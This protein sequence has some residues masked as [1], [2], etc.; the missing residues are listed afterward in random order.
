M[1]KFRVSYA[2]VSQAVKQLQHE[3]YGRLQQTDIAHQCYRHL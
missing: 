1:K 2:T 3:K